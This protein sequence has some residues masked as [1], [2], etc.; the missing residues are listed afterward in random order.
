M[1]TGWGHHSDDHRMRGL[2]VNVFKSISR[3]EVTATNGN[4]VRF[5]VNADGDLKVNARKGDH[6][7]SV[8][9]IPAA[10]VPAFVAW[11]TGGA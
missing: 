3:Y 9:V 4:T 6:N 1:A 10:E 7:Q 5:D 2:G 11:L 8:S